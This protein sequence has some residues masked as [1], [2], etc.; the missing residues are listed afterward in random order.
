MTLTTGLTHSSGLARESLS[1]RKVVVTLSFTS[2]D[3]LTHLNRLAGLVGLSVLTI[4]GW[5]DRLN[6]WF[7]PLVTKKKNKMTSLNCK[8]RAMPIY[9]NLLP[10][11]TFTLVEEPAIVAGIQEKPTGNFKKE[12]SQ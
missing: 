4:L 2:G 3:R 11:V 6:S 5:L 7:E 8:E 9:D 12:S 1:I 10:T